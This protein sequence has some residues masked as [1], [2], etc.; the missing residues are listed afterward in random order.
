M[1]IGLNPNA[2][3][4]KVGIVDPNCNN[5]FRESAI[6]DKQRRYLIAGF[7]PGKIVPMFLI[8]LAK[9]IHHPITCT[10]AAMTTRIYNHRGICSHK[11]DKK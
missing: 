11:A 10:S 2:Q 4:L 8:T 5:N 7:V 3:V 1:I 6:A 9:K